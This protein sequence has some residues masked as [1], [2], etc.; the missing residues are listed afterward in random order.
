MS[1][2]RFLV[3][4]LKSLAE[5]GVLERCQIMERRRGTELD[6]YTSKVGSSTCPVGGIA[7]E[8]RATKGLNTVSR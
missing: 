7:R 4:N 8:V 3:I 1:S 6:L 2:S 5:R